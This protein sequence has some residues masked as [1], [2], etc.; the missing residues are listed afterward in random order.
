[1]A[2]SK[3]AVVSVSRA[4]SPNE[5]IFNYLISFTHFSHLSSRLSVEAHWKEHIR[6]LRYTCGL[7]KTFAY[8][9][10]GDH[11]VPVTQ[12]L[13]HEFLRTT[14]VVEASIQKR[15]FTPAVLSRCSCSLPCSIQVA[16]SSTRTRFDIPWHVL[17]RAA[18]SVH[19]CPLI[20]TSRHHHS[21][22][23]SIKR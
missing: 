11:T 13:F 15:A 19:L 21:P 2:S 20:W 6:E 8:S 4:S 23:H 12:A 10:K 3:P 18:H 22:F 17:S 7:G 1:M 16:S 9:S 14:D 5:V